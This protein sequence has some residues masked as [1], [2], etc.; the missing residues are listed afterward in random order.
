MTEI[1]RNRT[2]TAML[3]ACLLAGGAE[4]ADPETKGT[5]MTAIEVIVGD[6]VLPATLDDTPAGRDFAALLPLELTLSD[7]HG[8]EK[9]ADLPR[10]LDTTGAPASYKPETG[11]ITLYAPWGNLAIFY[12]PFSDSHGL[13]RLGAFDG[14]IDALLTGGELPVRI[15]RAD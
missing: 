10:A 2:G 9:I 4:A 6:T 5:E 1:R 7:Y 11:D 12:K 14:P 15:E 13:V 8:I 3:I